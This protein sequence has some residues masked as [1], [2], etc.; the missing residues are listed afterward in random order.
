M[1]R[2]ERIEE[3]RC[4]NCYWY[5]TDSAGFSYDCQHY[6]KPIYSPCGYFEQKLKREK[7]DTYEQYQEEWN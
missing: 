5:W 4:E 1:H 2:E 7:V 6:P 3:D